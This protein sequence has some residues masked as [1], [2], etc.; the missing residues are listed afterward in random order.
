[1]GLVMQKSEVFKDNEKGTHMLLCLLTLKG[2]HFEKVIF[3]E[4]SNRILLIR[5]F[6]RVCWV[7][8]KKVFNALNIYVFKSPIPFIFKITYIFKIITLYRHILID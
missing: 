4:S 7:S 2:W 1:M 6:V 8:V 5:C 3:L